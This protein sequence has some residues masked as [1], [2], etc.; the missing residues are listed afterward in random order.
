MRS[1][2]FRENGALRVADERYVV[3]FEARGV[4]HSVD[5]FFEGDNIVGPL[6]KRAPARDIALERDEIAALRRRPTATVD[7]ED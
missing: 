1:E 4:E 7:E 3:R 2:A 5:P 6:A